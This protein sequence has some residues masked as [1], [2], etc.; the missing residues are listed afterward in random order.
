VLGALIDRHLPPDWADL[1]DARPGGVV[2]ENP[3]RQPVETDLFA[4]AG[5]FSCGFKQADW[6][7]IAAN[8]R[9]VDASR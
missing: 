6:H 7:A 5:G 3:E 1:D 9:D 8:E 2:V 4:G